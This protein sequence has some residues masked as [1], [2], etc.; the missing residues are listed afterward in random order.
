MKT[1]YDTR[2][3]TFPREYNG[4]FADNDIFIDC[5]HNCR[6]FSYGHGILQ[7]YIPSI[8]RGHN[9]VKA[10]KEDFKEEIIFDIEESSTE[11]LFKFHAKHLDKLVPML[12]PKTSAADRSP[13]S[14][15]NLPKAKYDI[16][17]EDL[18][19]YKAIVEK[20][21]K[22]RVLELSHITNS[23]L[24]SLVTKKNTWEDI[25]V[26]MGI[27]CLKNKEYIHSIGKWDDYIDYLENNI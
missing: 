25:K 9:I 21:G 10:I 1:E 2:L 7:A 8:G 12:K 26:D 6:I 17:T 4:Q 11:V 5:Y 15:K 16:P 18:N 23:Y 22:S 14:S 24:Q 20:V 13:F 27:K 19:K 3:N